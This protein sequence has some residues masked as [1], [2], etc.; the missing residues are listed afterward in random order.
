[1]FVILRQDK[2]LIIFN[3]QELAYIIQVNGNALKKQIKQGY[4]S[5]LMAKQQ[6]IMLSKGFT[7]RSSSLLYFLR[8]AYILLGICTKFV[9]EF[10]KLLA[11]RH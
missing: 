8:Q 1:M 10:Y 6:A 2:D 9:Q 7:R 4:N 5:N 3:K 11:Y